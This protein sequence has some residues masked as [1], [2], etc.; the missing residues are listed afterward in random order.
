MGTNWPDFVLEA[1]R[2]LKD[3]GLLFVAEITS[4][5]VDVNAFVKGMK[6]EGG[7]KALKVTKVKEYFYL[8]VFEKKSESKFNDW[9][10]GFAKQLKP[11]LYKKR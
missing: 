10:D 3:K 4:R 5:I 1:N 7:F 11:C 6:N 9:S 8:M 2:V